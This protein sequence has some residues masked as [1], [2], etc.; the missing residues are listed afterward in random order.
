MLSNG[1]TVGAL[2]AIFLH[3]AIPFNAEEDSAPSHD[4][5]L[6]AT[7]T[8]NQ[9]YKDVSKIFLSLTFKTSDSCSTNGGCRM[10]ALGQQDVRQLLLSSY[11]SRLDEGSTG[12]HW[13]CSVGHFSCAI[14]GCAR[15]LSCQ[16]PSACCQ[17]SLV[18]LHGCKGSALS[19]SYSFLLSAAGRH[20]A[21]C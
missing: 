14:K 7:A 2:S 13:A 3:L 5:L 16:F 1:F 4:D 9:L 10:I 20:S 19:A 12:V 6:P 21:H 8:D 17:D 15:C 18:Q 11:M